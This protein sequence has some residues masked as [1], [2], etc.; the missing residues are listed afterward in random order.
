LSKQQQ[1]ATPGK[2][3]VKTKKKSAFQATSGTAF[4][5]ASFNNTIVSITDPAGHVIS[6]SSAGKVNFSGSRKSS[7]FA[8]TV[9]AQDAGKSAVAA[10]MREVEVNLNG[11][12]AGRE[13]A[14][15]GLQS[16][17]LEIKAIR[18]TTPVPH[19]GCRPRKRRRV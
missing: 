14:V 17:G 18:D 15:R 10:G 9:A 7:A 5:K 13:S 16:A 4:V 12:G 19:N 6:W 8:A 11:A 3:P 1:P 2:K